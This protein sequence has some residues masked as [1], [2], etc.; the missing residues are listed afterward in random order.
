MYVCIHVGQDQAKLRQMA[1]T[2]PEAADAAEALA[3]TRI[4]GLIGAPCEA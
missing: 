1:E 2:C 3:G 4:V